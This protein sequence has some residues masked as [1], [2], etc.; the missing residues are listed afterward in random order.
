M[1]RLIT[2]INHNTQVVYLEIDG[3]RIQLSNMQMNGFNPPSWTKGVK[4]E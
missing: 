2:E 3:I 1:E 4:S